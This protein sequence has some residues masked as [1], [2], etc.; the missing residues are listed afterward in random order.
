MNPNCELNIN[1]MDPAAAEPSPASSQQCSRHSDGIRL[2]L[3]GLAGAVSFSDHDLLIFIADALYQLRPQIRELTDGI[4]NRWEKECF[5]HALV[6][7]E[8]VLHREGIPT[9]KADDPGMLTEAEMLAGG[10]VFRVLEDGHE[11]IVCETDCL[12]AQR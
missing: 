7:A 2:K 4:G 12:A 10:F 1:A 3:P 9:D 6:A 5:V 11:H 8:A